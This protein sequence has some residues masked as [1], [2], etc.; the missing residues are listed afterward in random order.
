MVEERG[1]LICLVSILVLCFAGFS[2][3][4]S[5]LEIRYSTRITEEVYKPLRIDI[6]DQGRIYVSDPYR[7]RVV[8]F[9]GQGG[10]LWRLENVLGPLGVAVD[11]RGRL[12]VGTDGRVEVFDSRGQ[13][14]FSLGSGDGE[15]TQPNDMAISPDGRIYVVDSQEDRIKVYDLGG[16]YLFS[17]GSPGSDNGQ[18]RF[19]AGIAVDRMRGEV[20]VT[21]QMNA[22]I[23]VFDL[24]GEWLRSFGEYTYSTDGGQTWVYE[25]THTRP[26]GVAVD[27][28]GRIYVVDAYQNRV[29]VVDHEGQF[30]AFIGGYG[31]Q[32]GHFRLPMDAVVDETGGQ[33]KLLVTSMETGAVEVFSSPVTAID[34]QESGHPLPETFRLHQ[35]YP[36]PFNSE[37][38][39][40]FE[41]VSE[42]EVKVSVTNLLGQQIQVL[43]DDRMKAGTHQVR[44]DG[45]D[46][47]GLAVT[48]GIYF[49]EVQ[50]GT[51]EGSGRMVLIR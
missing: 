47:N 29:Q 36:N 14:L 49:Y 26:Q 16:R 41:L 46:S 31:E 19:P 39:I 35:N 27:S 15:F 18:F 7:H 9:D 6:D 48:S 33:V 32:A 20:I 17:F 5:A 21:D 25:G 4:L 38:V 24:E 2:P 43:I 42:C 44:W 28:Y 40:Q 37:T 11:A 51:S 8:L 13:Y 34:E 23:Q 12:F 50:V 1:F 30:R 45:R 3:V 10:F 22:R